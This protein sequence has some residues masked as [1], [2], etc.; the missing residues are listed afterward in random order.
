M[1]NNSNLNTA[2]GNIKWCYIYCFSVPKSCLTLCDPMDC[3]KHGFPVLHYL[4][5]FVQTHVHWVSDAIQ[6]SH[7]VSP[8]F[9]SCPQF[10][11]SIRSLPM[12]QLFM[13]GGQSIGAS[14]SASVLPLNIHGWFPL[15][16]LV[17]SP[18]H[19]RHS[20]E[21]SPV[22][23]FESISSSTLSLLY[24]PTFTSIHDYWKNHSFD[25]MDLYW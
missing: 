11:P 13:S 16:W 2:N 20:Q 6:S 18:C 15:D 24:G 23:Q 8:P 25:Y 17:W 5:E 4:P 1:W 7:P 10:F 3:S 22:P 12:S 14:A 9:S 19:P 21:F